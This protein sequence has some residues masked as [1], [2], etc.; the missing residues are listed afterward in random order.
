[1]KTLVNVLALT[2]V[3]AMATVI[4]ASYIGVVGAIAVRVARWFL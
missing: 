3:W 4:V 2:F 1:M